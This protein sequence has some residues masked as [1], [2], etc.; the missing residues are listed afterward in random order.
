MSSFRQTQIVSQELLNSNIEEMLKEHLGNIDLEKDL[1]LCKKQKEAYDL[2]KNE[3]NLLILGPAGTGKS[4][5]IKTM[6]EYIKNKKQEKKMTLCATTGIAAY[7]IGGM[8]IYSFM[9]IGTGEGDV[10]YLV[11][12]IIRKKGQAD[13]IRN[14]DV[15][16]IDEISMMSAA[17]F[18]KIEEICRRVRKNNRYFGGIQVILTGDFLQLLPVMKQN[19]EIYKET[20]ER[21]IIESKVFNDIFKKDKNVIILYENFRQK[22]DSKYSEILNRIRVGEHTE[23]DIKLLNTRN[24]IKNKELKP[25]KD[26]IE[27]VSSNKKAKEINV[28]ELTKEGYIYKSKYK[29]SGKDETVLDLLM[30]ELQLQFKQKEIDEIVL[31]KN[32]RVMLIKNLDVGL[33]L[34]N[35]SIGTIKRFVQNLQTKEM[36][37]E[38]LFDNKITKLITKTEWELDM[39]GNRVIALQ[40]PLTLAYSITIHKSQSLTLD[41]AILDLEDCFTYHMVYVSLSRVKSLDGLYLKSFDPK[42]ILVNEKMKEFNSKLTK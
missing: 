38:V 12:K 27:L 21:M 1:N 22:Q 16:V 39:N 8:T 37:P 30:K 10:D 24:L 9:G 3:E 42:K 13:R 7:N 6:E 2:F 26:I 20:D 29:V 36:E 23:N 17:I 15:L 14:T 28:K 25:P 18:E 5:V 11:K 34:V 4:K 32:N 40:I 41:S 31:C 33:G 35:G 19:K